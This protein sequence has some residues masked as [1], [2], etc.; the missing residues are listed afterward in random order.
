MHRGERTGLRILMVTPAFLP[1]LGGVE[2]HV[3]EVARR[4]PQYGC[5]V[6]V[7]TTDPSGR[8]PEAAHGEGYAVRRVRARPSRSDVRLAPSLGRRMREAPWDLVHVQ[9]YHTFVAPHAMAVAARHRIPYV[10]T[11]H[12]GGHSS[13]W[14]NR[15][16]WSQR[17]ILRPLLARARRLVAVADFEID[18]YGGELGLPREQFALVPN[19]VALPSGPADAVGHV[20]NPVVI[21]SV[22]RLE[23]YKGHQRAIAALPRVLHEEPKARLW[24]AGTGP[25]EGE[26]RQLARRLGVAERVEIQAIP[27]D[28]PQEMARRLARVSV[29]TLF[30]DAETHPIAVLEARALD[31]PVVVAET[32]GLRPFVERGEAVGVAPD[33]SPDDVAAAILR[34]IREPIAAPPVAAHT[35]DDCTRALLDVYRRA[36]EVRC[37]S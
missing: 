9:S 15:V 19:G 21:A 16:R 29:M 27:A 34:Q 6:T 35:W 32:L 3:H 10:V 12:G 11:F 23:R 20:D 7:L 14:R 26:L 36:L 2:R 1:E 13:A 31:R 5:D 33:A 22:G 4:L 8:L 24:I 37:A 28:Q 30:S 18:L 17:Q 25:Y